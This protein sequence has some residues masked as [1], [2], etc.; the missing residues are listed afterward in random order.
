MQVREG[1][2]IQGAAARGSRPFC[3]KAWRKT[4]KSARRGE[5]CVV[6]A[7]GG[8]IN[9]FCR[10]AAFPFSPVAFSG[11]GAQR[12]SQPVHPAPGA[13]PVPAPDAEPSAYIADIACRRQVRRQKAGSR[14]AA[15]RR[16]N[17]Y[18]GACGYHSAR[19]GVIT[20]HASARGRCHTRRCGAGLAAFLQKGLAKNPKIRAAGR[21][22]RCQC[23]RRGDKQILPLCRFPVFPRGLFGRRG[24][25]KITAC[26]S[27]VRRPARSGAGRGMRRA[28]RK[29][30]DGV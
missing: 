21:D 1:G 10:F 6:N 24:T 13:P 2:A 9:R 26:P 28:R 30:S 12:K 20:G 17:R 5:M 4:R 11:G 18:S 16:R 23:G 14:R 29:R 15:Q 8:G 3:K 27:R 25:T 22:V 19:K 7:G